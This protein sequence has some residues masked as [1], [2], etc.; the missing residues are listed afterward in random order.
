MLVLTRKRN[1]TIVING[2]I[3]ILVVAIRGN[4]VRLGIEAPDSVA[5][6]REEVRERLGVGE[7]RAAPAS[8][9]AG[10][11][12]IPRGSISPAQRPTTP[13][14]RE[15]G[16]REEYTPFGAFPMIRS[17]LIGIDNSASGI[18]AQDLGVRWAERFDARLTAITIVDGHGALLPAELA[19]VGA[20]HHA[21]DVTRIADNRP[22]PDTGYWHIEKKFDQ[23]CHEAGVA[24]E[25]IGDVGSPHVQICVEAQNHDIVLLGQRSRFVFGRERD[26]GQAVGRIIQS[27]P[28]PVVVVPQASYGGESVVV[29]YDG[30]LQASRALWAFVASGLGDGAEVHVVTV[31]DSQDATRCAQRAITFLQSHRI[32]ATPQIV[33]TSLPPAES[34][35][36]KVRTLDAGIL[37]IGAYGQSVVREFFL[38]SVTRTVLEECRVPV[39]C[40][41]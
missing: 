27:C 5:I 10:C 25:R 15:S 6:L 2:D 26:P 18:A 23:R 24:L 34:I 8:T 30:T 7:V 16:G 20:S 22:V 21:V 31:G 1:E 4:Q 35:L 40:F 39:F 28:R 37:V 14:A 9:G 33:V 12:P 41:H 17:I 11:G 3:R 29:A 36:K 32:A 38:G 19:P 13:R